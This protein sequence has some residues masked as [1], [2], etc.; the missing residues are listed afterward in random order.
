MAVTSLSVCTPDVVRLRDPTPATAA[1]TR[2]ARP[3]RSPLRAAPAAARTDRRT[4]PHVSRATR[5]LPGRCPTPRTRAAA[6]G[7]VAPRARSARPRRATTPAPRATDAAAAQDAP[8]SWPDS[9]RTRGITVGLGVVVFDGD[10]GTVY[11]HGGL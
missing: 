7:D 5:G 8:I 1:R 11:R 3:A 10:S 9:C 2:V 6:A 4:R